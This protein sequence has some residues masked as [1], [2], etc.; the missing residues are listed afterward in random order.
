MSFFE[1]LRKGVKNIITNIKK[2]MAARAVENKEI[3]EIE[4]EAAFQERKKQA[5][6]TAAYRVQLKGKQDR[7]HIKHPV[8]YNT[9]QSFGMT[10]SQLQTKQTK[11]KKQEQV[12]QEL[13]DPNMAMKMVN[14]NPF[15]KEHS[16]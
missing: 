10:G 6:K 9:P 12:Q 1:T 11:T 4:H 8:N 3:K 2:D 15:K 7:E 13:F 16:Q 5:K 14:Y